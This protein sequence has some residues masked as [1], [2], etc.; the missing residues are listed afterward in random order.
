M[1]DRELRLRKNLMKGIQY[2]GIMV[3]SIL[4][5]FPVV[6]II[7]TAFKATV[8]IG[9]PS[10]IIF[11]PVLTHFRTVLREWHL[12]S[13]FKNSLMVGLSSAA[14]A[15]LV[16][17]LAAYSL[18][19]L[20]PKQKRLIAYEF[21]SFRIMPPIVVLLPI[22]IITTKLHLQGKLPL[23]ILIYT[24]M[25][26]PLVIWVMTGFFKEIPEEMEEA[27]L[28]DG[29]GRLGVFLRISLPLVI[30]GLVAT[31]I[32]SLIFAWNEFMFANVLTVQ[33]TKTLPVIAAMSVKPRFILWGASA[34]V[35]VL[36]LMPVLILGLAV[37]KY[38]VR[39]LTFGAVKG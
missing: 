2:L 26:L 17:S 14:L 32:I 29:C 28:V 30:P 20:N 9:D 6:W 12:L 10:T 33:E 27:A 39:G 13:F 31:G 7:M 34:A 3:I 16:G 36:V 15:T 22:F 21:L 5:L 38:L 1:N 19:K 25:N 37:Q 18:A 11:S 8:D 23:L 24:S 4:F 35:G